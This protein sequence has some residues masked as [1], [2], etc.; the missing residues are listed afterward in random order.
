MRRCSQTI[1]ESRQHWM[2]SAPRWPWTLSRQELVDAVHA[3]LVSAGFN[4]SADLA[5]HIDDL[6]GVL[7]MQ[8]AAMAQPADQAHATDDFDDAIDQL[9][10]DYDMTP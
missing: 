2:R 10:A 3:R 9:R 7:I 6:M 4:P 1:R 5:D 8:G